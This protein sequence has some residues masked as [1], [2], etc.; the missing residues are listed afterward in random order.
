LIKRLSSCIEI[1]L[2]AEGRIKTPEQ[3]IKC[4]E[5]GAYSVVIG[6][7]ITRPQLIT[8]SFTK[9]MKSFKKII[10]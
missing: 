2:I 3:L 4:M 10:L 5:C 8:E 9:A 6:S 1:P 7:A